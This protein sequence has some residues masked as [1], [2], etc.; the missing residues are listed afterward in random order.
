MTALFESILRCGALWIPWILSNFRAEGSYNKIV[1]NLLNGRNPCKTLFKRLHGLMVT[2]MF[3]YW[4]KIHDGI[5]VPPDLAR[6]RIRPSPARSVSA[7][8]QHDR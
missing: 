8:Q 7:S 3:L 1:K 2:T 5:L 4:S 6:L